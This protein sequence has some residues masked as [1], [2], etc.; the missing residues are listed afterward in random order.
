[1]TFM[2]AYEEAVDAHWGLGNSVDILKLYWKLSASASLVILLP[3]RAC[4]MPMPK[5]WWQTSMIVKM[6]DDFHGRL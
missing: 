2:G 4:L 5:S 3:V 6:G 1:M